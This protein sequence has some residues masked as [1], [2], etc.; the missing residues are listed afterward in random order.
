MSQTT[1]SALNNRIV[2]FVN[3]IP[4][5][6]ECAICFKI[7]DDPVRC[8]L[9]CRVIFCSVCMQQ[10][11]DRRR[12]CPTCGKEIDED[13][14]IRELRDTRIRSD[15]LDYTVYCLNKGPD[16]SANID[17]HSST[18]SSKAALDDDKCLWTGKYNL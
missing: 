3:A 14:D 10:A 18:D 1:A 15:I 5:E 12:K 8:G 6:M 13:T 11:L 7:A 16:Q 17:Q 4:K 2:T 9:S